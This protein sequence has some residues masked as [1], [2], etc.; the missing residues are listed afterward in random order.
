MAGSGIGGG[1]PS[2]RIN[3]W[4]IWGW[5][6]STLVELPVGPLI[7]ANAPPPEGSSIHSND[8]TN[9]PVPE[10]PEWSA[11]IIC[12]FLMLVVS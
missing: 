2:P 12:D 5:N 1:T 10:S 9:R 8:P 3:A 7:R 11:T 6:S 4:A